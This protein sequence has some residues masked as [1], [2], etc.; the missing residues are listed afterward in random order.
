MAVME[1]MPSIKGV[2]VLGKVFFHIELGDGV[3]AQPLVRLKVLELKYDK[4]LLQPWSLG[5]NPIEEVL[6][7]LNNLSVITATFPSLPPK[8]HILVPSLHGL[9]TRIKLYFEELGLTVV[10]VVYE[11]LPR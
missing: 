9:P 1:N 2:R 11:G 3:L 10:K 5:F 8:L 4:V 6:R 7:K